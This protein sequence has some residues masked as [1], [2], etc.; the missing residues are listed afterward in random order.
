M[1]F[2]LPNSA[3]VNK[4]IPRKKFLEKTGGTKIKQDFE[5]IEKIVWSYNLSPKTVNISGTEKVEEIQIFT[6]ILKVE[7]IPKKAIEIMVKL[8]PYPILFVV[9][10]GEKK[11]FSIFC[12]EN[13]KFYYSDWN[14]KKSFDFFGNN[15]EEVYQ[16]LVISFLEIRGKNFEESLK[17]QSRINTLRREIKSLENKIRREKQFKYKVELNRKLIN[18]KNELKKIEGS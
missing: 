2:K 6:I 15:L 4:I 9:E 8:I 16:N 14:E 13:Q 3:L 1:K 7:E 11:I 18:L 12:K 5:K 10:F 17:I